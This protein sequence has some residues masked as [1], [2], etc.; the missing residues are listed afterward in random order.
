MREPYETNLSDSMPTFLLIQNSKVTETI[1]G[2]DASALRSA[3][4]K[5][6][7]SSGRGGGAASSGTYFS[8]SGR[9]LGDDASSGKKAGGASAGAAGLGNMVGGVGTVADSMVRFMG[10]YV[11]TLFSFDAYSAAEASPLAVTKPAR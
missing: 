10:L 6:L 9:R 1:R 11:T 8:G 5:A 2:A 3:V 7:G 4:Q